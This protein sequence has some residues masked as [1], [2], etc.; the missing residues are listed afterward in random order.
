MK[1]DKQLDNL[2]S[3]FEELEYE[4]K[5][6]GSLKNARNKA[7]MKSYLSTLDYSVKRLQLLQESVE[8]LLLEKRQFEV[9]QQQIQ[10]FKTKI[11]NLSREYHTSYQDIIMIMSQL[12]QRK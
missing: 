12:K 9:K 4:Q 2:I 8:D 11:I 6:T 3:A 1:S 5:S 10:T 7:Q